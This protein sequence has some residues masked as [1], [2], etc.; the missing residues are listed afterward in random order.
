MVLA[1]RE[2][3][4]DLHQSAFLRSRVACRDVSS[5]E[6]TEVPERFVPAQMRGELVEAE[7]LVRYWWAAQLAD[8][9]RALDA[10][11]GLGYGARILQAAG[12]LS[13]DGVD[14]SDATVEAARMEAGEAVQ[15]A[16]A[17]VAALPFA[18]DTFDLV[19][20][21]EVI[22][23]IDERERALDELAR[24]L[25][26]GGV[27]AISSP[28]RLQ[29][30]PGNPHHVHEYEPEE[31]RDALAS[32]FRQVAL[33]RQQAWTASAIVDDEELAADRLEHPLAL[34]SAKVSGRRGGEETYT[35]ALAA[36]VPLPSMRAHA[37]LTGALELQRWLELYDEQRAVLERQHA[38]LSGE[39]ARDASALAAHRRLRQAE[40]ELAESQLRVV[41]AQRERDDALRRAADAEALVVR[42]ERVYRD[43]MSS[44]SWRMTSPLRRLK[45][46]R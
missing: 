22:E 26:P 1:R 6:P 43:L 27:L 39:R 44:A 36:N 4:R 40:H 23:H 29:Y 18:D 5:V 17:D 30:P 7:H 46:L 14:V 34:S 9:R 41:E 8:G 33:H 32:R 21:F 19:V 12:A 25:A 11:C 35:V 37:V 20:C 28:N 15:L 38:L 3:E 10:G 24:V 45:Q 13:V 42:A 31:L 2:D 16:V